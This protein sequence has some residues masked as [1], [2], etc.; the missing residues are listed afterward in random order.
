MSVD[1][2]VP[3]PVGTKTVTSPTTSSSS[4]QF[5]GTGKTSRDCLCTNDTDAIGFVEFGSTAPTATTSGMPVRPG[6][7]IV[8]DKEGKEFAAV[9]MGAAPTSGSFYFTPGKGS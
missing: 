4:V 1:N 2:F 9:V 8:V 6:A 5:T 7:Q 3:M